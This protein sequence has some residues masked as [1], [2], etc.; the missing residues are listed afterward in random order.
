MQPYHFKGLGESFQLML[1]NIG[2]CSK[3][4][5]I[6]KKPFF[7][8]KTGTLIPKTVFCFYRALNENLFFEHFTQKIYKFEPIKKIK[9][10]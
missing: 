3:V 2:L 8:P 7:T 6:H 4:P 10:G 1:L 5:K 9:F